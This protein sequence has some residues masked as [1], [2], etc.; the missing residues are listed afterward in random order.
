MIF[1][2]E[3]EGNECHFLQ[4]SNSFTST[5]KCQNATLLTILKGYKKG[6]A[7][8]R[9]MRTENRKSSLKVILYTTKCSCCGTPRKAAFPQGWRS[10]GRIQS[11]AA[12]ASVPIPHK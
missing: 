1:D 10:E 5:G 6:R 12:P 4:R 2:I 8:W 3:K 9:K 7:A 11:R